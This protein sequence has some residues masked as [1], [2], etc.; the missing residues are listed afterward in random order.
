MKH[1]FVSIGSLEGQKRLEQL[2][3]VGPGGV[4][5]TKTKGGHPQ[6]PGSGE[7]QKQGCHVVGC[8]DRACAT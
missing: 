3:A 4:M 8:V 5:R 2:P 1:K 7:E 6:K